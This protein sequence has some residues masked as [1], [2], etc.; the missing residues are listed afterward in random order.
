MLVTVMGMCVVY[1]VLCCVMLY[2]IV[3]V[4]VHIRDFSLSGLMHLCW[5]VL[6]VLY[7]DC[8][9]CTVCI[10]EWHDVI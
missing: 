4:C 10:S 7:I 3:R 9:N 6:C 1:I 5:L 2:Y 8:I